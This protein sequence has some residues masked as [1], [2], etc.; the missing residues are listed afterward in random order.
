MLSE[1]SNGG[2]G[3]VRAASGGRE[4][5]NTFDSRDS[6]GARSLRA[7]RVAVLGA[8]GIGRF[9]V[10]ELG[11]A[12]AHVVAILGSR[13]ESA[14]ATAD[15]LRATYGVEALALHRLEDLLALELDAVSIATPHELHYEQ[16]LA[17]LRSGLAVSCEKPLFWEPGLTASTVE[18]RLDALESYGAAQRL[19]LN[20]ANVTLFD[21]VASQTGSPRS[22]ACHFTTNGP[23]RGAD[24]GVDLLPHG[25]A[26]ALRWMGAHVV[27]PSPHENDPARPSGFTDVRMRS[28][29]N[30]F[31][32]TARLR[33]VDLRFVFRQEPN[34]EKC[35]ELVLNGVRYRRVARMLG[36]A[37]RISLQRDPAL[38]GGREL[39]LADPFRVHFRRFVASLRGED[40]PL[41]GWRLA[42]AVQ[43]AMVALLASA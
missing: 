12:G 11:R 4:A 26:L 33:G 18:T 24:I 20:L 21:A 3:P 25:L 8:S 40:V 43:R 9:H 41:A 23:H 32:L 2:R 39:P 29:E 7:P 35:L 19:A 10:R 15:A 1:L 17:A 13:P 37:Y 6:A 31:E 42:V 14:A 36:G 16:T 27:E 5:P 34:V 22:F 30:D 38:D 28:R